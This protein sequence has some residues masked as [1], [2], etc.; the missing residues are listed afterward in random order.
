MLKNNILAFCV[1]LFSFVSVAQSPDTMDALQQI[2]RNNATLK[3]F[4]SF[5]ES[6]KLSQKTSNNLPDPQ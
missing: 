4:S 2:E 6:K 3:A 1:G 5:L